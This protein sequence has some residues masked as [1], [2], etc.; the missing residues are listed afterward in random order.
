MQVGE[1]VKAHYA[2]RDAKPADNTDLAGVYLQAMKQC[3]IDTKNMSQA[4]FQAILEATWPT[5]EEKQE[6]VQQGMKDIY[7]GN[8]HTSAAQMVKESM[9]IVDAGLT[10]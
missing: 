6:V 1:V 4:T 7:A 10:T 2:E 9:G 5:P 3:D 8:P